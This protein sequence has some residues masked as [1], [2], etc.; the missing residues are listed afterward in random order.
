MSELIG[1]G[2]T[3]IIYR[4]GNIATKVYTNAS[5]DEVKKEMEHQ[6]FAYNSGLAVPNVYD[7]KILDDGRV[8]LDM[9][10]IDGSP[11]MHHG[12]NEIE[13]ADAINILVKLQYN[14]HKIQASGLPKLSD[15]ITQKILSTNLTPKIKNAL[16]T[17]LSQLDD[18]SEK[19]CHGDF[20]P[21]NILYDG[22]KH[23]IIDWVDAAAGNPFVDAC[24]TY[25]LIKPEMKELAEIYLQVFSSEIGCQPNHILN[26]QPVVAAARL[27]ENIESSSRDYLY[28][29]VQAW[30]E[31]LNS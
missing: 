19:L 12:M 29:I 14:M 16:S 26:W 22:H 2:A 25:L 13:I 17:L 7:V 18:K 10:Y 8:A 11:L 28:G 4:N 15:R 31:G 23:W 1:K 30:Y 3:A 5:I 24:R 20:H 21:L 9:E 27:S 6:Q